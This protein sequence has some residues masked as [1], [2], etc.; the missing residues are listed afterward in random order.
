MMMILRLLRWRN[1]STSLT[2]LAVWSAA[3]A[4]AAVRQTHGMA[5]TTTTMSAHSIGGGGG[6]NNKCKVAIVG[7]GIAGL[8][9]AQKL[10][11][12]DDRFE[13]TCY[14][15]GRLRPGGRCSSRQVGDIAK[16]DDPTYPLLSQ[17]RYDHAAQLIA[18]PDPEQFPAF[19]QQVKEW[20]AQGILKEFPQGSVCQ[21]SKN[22]QTKPLSTSSSFYHATK[23]MGSLA[24]SMVES[25]GGSFQLE[26][27]VWVSPSSG[28]RYQKNTG[29]WKLQ[30]K[31]ETLG[32]YDQLILAHNGKCADRIMSNTPATDLHQLLRV[33][34]APTVPA[35]GGNKMTLNSLYSLTIVLPKSSSSSSSP[36]PLSRALPEP[37]QCGFLNH[38]HLRM[39]SCQSRKYPSMDN[40]SNSNSNSN[41]N[42]KYEVWN[43][44]SS[45]KFAKKY[46]APQEFLPPET[47]EQVSTLLL[48][49]VQ[50][51]LG[52]INNV[53]DADDNIMVL[54]PLEKRLQLWG[55]AVPLNVW[56]GSGEDAAAAQQQPFLWDETYQV[57]VCGDWLMEPS[58]AG[59]WTSG[60]AMAEHLLKMSSSRG[61]VGL[62]GHFERSESSSELGLAALPVV[63]GAPNSSGSRGT[64][65]PLPQ[66]AS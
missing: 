60:H 64:S 19:S 29:K 17:F 3:A 2:M 10:S 58:I 43:I 6:R 30:A 14:D 15:T 41:N 48:Q 56:R 52:L 18:D 53:N 61:T 11:Q 38:P 50:E 51:S 35:H 20:V 57:G 44:L 12:D 13:V 1:K 49:A 37:F 5:T 8:S 16:E 62:Q 28:V 34:F 21:I 9:C 42:D 39:I 65:K 24:T 36:S 7:G 40:T 4:A 26:Q 27:D 46:K 32:Y 23:G 59:A 63:G 25:S 47:V 54:S 33:N 22:G 31:G 66:A 45:A 55:A